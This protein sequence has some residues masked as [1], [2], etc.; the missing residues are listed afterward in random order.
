MEL[1]NKISLITGSGSGLG[2]ASAILFSNAG[3]KMS[4]VDIDE[5]SGRAK[6]IKRIQEKLK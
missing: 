4:V 1:K 2:R 6:S 5:K 3:A